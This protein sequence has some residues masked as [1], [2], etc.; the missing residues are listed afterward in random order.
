MAI[1]RLLP[2]AFAVPSGT[3]CSSRHRSQVTLPCMVHFSAMGVLWAFGVQA[4]LLG[5][6]VPRHP[7]R[8]E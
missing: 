2:F 7:Q 5:L 3:S 8:E 4:V 1:S 6:L